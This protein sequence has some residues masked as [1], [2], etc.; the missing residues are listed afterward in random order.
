MEASAPGYRAFRTTIALDTTNAE[1]T[2]IVVPLLLEERRGNLR[3][4]KRPRAFRKGEIGGAA[5]FL[6]GIATTGFGLVL[7]ISA[8]AS[9]GDRGSFDP[10]QSATGGLVGASIGILV[11]GAG[12]IVGGVFLSSRSD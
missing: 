2:T 3:E 10:P 9:Y 4:A 12:L 6:S 1:V 5:M 11:A 8:I 7:G